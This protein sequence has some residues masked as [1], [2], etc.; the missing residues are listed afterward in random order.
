MHRRPHRIES[1]RKAGG[2][3]DAKGTQAHS[4]RTT[5]EK[6]GPNP[7]LKRLDVLRHRPRRHAKLVCGIGKAAKPRGSLK[8][9][10]GVEQRSLEA[11]RETAIFIALVF[12][13]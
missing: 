1:L 12:L 7:I 3:L 2:D 8:G 13:S 4:L 11:R 5:L 10:Q 6:I 9:A